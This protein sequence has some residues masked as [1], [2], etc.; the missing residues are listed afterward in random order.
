MKVSTIR[1]S[2][3]LQTSESFPASEFVH[4][5]A[6]TSCWDKGKRNR[7]KCFSS[8]LELHQWLNK[9]LIGGYLSMCDY[10]NALLISER[11]QRSI[12]DK[13]VVII[14][15]CSDDYPINSYLYRYSRDD[16]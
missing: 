11:L 6:Y 8:F 13:P 2:V 10:N 14:R 16:I 3:S 9:L 15:D 5:T 4:V 1:F 7:T 12:S